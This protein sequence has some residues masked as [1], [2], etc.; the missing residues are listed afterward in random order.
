MTLRGARGLV[1]VLGLAVALGGCGVRPQVSPEL[2]PATAPTREA[3]TIT[4]QRG[5]GSSSSP[6]TPVP[7]PPAKSSP[8]P[9]SPVPT[10][11]RA[12]P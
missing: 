3:P 5:P 2:L 4:T 7:S 6:A 12:A 11:G 9:T 1:A 10:P 8:V